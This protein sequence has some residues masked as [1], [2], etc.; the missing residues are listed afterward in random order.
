MRRMKRVGRRGQRSRMGFALRRLGLVSVTLFTV[1]AAALV[2]ADDVVVASTEVALVDLGALTLEEF[3]AVAPESAVEGGVASPA[4]PEAP[5]GASRTDR[6]NRFSRDFNYWIIDHLL[7]PT[8]RGYNVIVPKPAQKG[9]G[10]FTDNLDR[11]RDIVQSLL[12]GKFRRA[13]R[14]STAFLVNSTAGVVGLFVILDPDSP[15]TG[16][17]TLGHHGLDTGHYL[18]IPFFPET[19]PRQVGGDLGDIFLDPVYWVGNAVDGAAGLG[20]T[21]GIR[22]VGGLND[23][24]SIMPSPFASK[25]EWDAYRELLRERHSYEEAK[26]LYYENQALDVQD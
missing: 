12:Q 9:V 21:I 4:P 3:S 19:A 17:E 1:A 25:S 22:I 18:V 5:E 10:N 7:E 8:A 24:A 6:F 26:R 23:L 11:P 15:E 16:N 14:H 2:R 13:G 20:V